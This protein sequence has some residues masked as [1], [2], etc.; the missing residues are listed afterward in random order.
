[1]RVAGRDASAGS[2]AEA[3][4]R[5]VELVGRDLACHRGERPVFRGISFRL[6]SGAALAVTGANG[7]GKSSL[8][9]LLAT[10]LRPQT[11]QLLWGSTPVWR[12]PASY[13][14][15]LHYVGHL[16]A[17]KP[18]LSA[19]EML[20]SWAV[21]RGVATPSRSRIDAALAAFALETAA[22]WPC[23]WL[24]AGQRR[25]LALARLLVSPAPI[26]LL[27]E[28]SAGLDG[29]GQERLE[30]AIAAHLAAGGRIVVA[31]HLPIAI[32]AATM[33]TLDAFRATADAMR[34]DAF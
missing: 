7:S 19:R 4:S 1:M 34:A 13:R 33:L 18:A 22:D 31:T 14:A 25:R 21:L 26:W 3:H 16:D 8:L 15:R 6:A 30:Q 17:I 10:L 23:R 11:G 20:R 32:A 12:D 2:L 24:S 29:D 5:Q 28:P 27:D 9:R